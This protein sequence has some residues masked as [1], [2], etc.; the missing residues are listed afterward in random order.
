MCLLVCW[1][2]RFLSATRHLSTLRRCLRV[3]ERAGAAVAGGPARAG[4]R[5]HLQE[6]ARACRTTSQRKY[7]CADA[8]QKQN[9]TRAL[10]GADLGQLVFYKTQINGSLGLMA[11]TK[12]ECSVK[13]DSQYQKRSDQRPA[14]CCATRARDSCRFTMYTSRRPAALRNHGNYTEMWREENRLQLK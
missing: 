13:A 4:K 12:R 9:R 8:F 1:F 14:T 3:A 11:F 2:V 7:R 6:H 10:V 5:M